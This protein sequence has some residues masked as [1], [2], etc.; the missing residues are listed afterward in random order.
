[1]DRGMKRFVKLCVT[2]LYEVDTH[3]SLSS[4]PSISEALLRVKC[5]TAYRSN[6]FLFF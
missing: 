3:L 5:Q 4:T 6:S 1:M 2:S